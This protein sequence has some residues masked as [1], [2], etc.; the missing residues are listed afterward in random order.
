MPRTASACRAGDRRTA[1]LVAAGVLALGMAGDAPALAGTWD[2]VDIAWRDDPRPA[3]DV[4]GEF[5][6][7]PGRRGSRRPRRATRRS[8]PVGVPA[9]APAATAVPAER[10]AVRP[11]DSVSAA[12][13]HRGQRYGA[14]ANARQRFDL[15]LPEGCAG[16]GTPLVVWIRGTDWRG[17]QQD[18]CPL[19]WLVRHGFAVAS[20]D[21]RPSDVAQ[22]PAQLD[23][24][25]AALA[26]LRQDAAVW[27]IDPE[28][29]C[30]FGRAGGGHLAALIAFT[31]SPP[32]TGT[33]QPAD[34]PGDVAAV[35]AIGAPFQLTSLGIAHQRG[36]S[37]ASRLVGGPLP[38]FREAARHASPLEHVG[39]DAPPTLL[40]H[41]TRDAN[42]P[43]DQSLE[44]DRALKAA[45]A[46]STL[47]LLDGDAAPVDA[48]SP[49][50]R[51]IRRF[52]ER[53]IGSGQAHAPR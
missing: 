35:G 31:A 18:D 7:A 48:E 4:P 13:T 53:V 2:G 38:E 45:G 20:I 15:H 6:P 29:I 40:L 11:A 34:Q 17:G 9:E 1:A 36:T 30:V 47:V 43:A 23:D 52:L 19:L 25:R 5:A 46:D 27:G 39:A 51:A 22:F 26:T 42:V 3:A 28:R 8:R 24:C 12:V 50:G 44:L 21:Y 10:P 16:G 14:E 41:A 49:S 32:A 33:V 37:A